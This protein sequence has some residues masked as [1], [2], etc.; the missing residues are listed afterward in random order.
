MPKQPKRK[1]NWRRIVGLF[2]LVTLIFSIGYA[3]VR[4]HFAP[5]GDEAVGN[6]LQRSDYLLM[7]IQCCLGLIVI[8]LPGFLDR[9]FSFDLPNY[10]TIMYFVFFVLRDLSRRSPPVFLSRAPLGHLLARI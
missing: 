10:M 5:S 9:K 3:L 2:V 1:L 6:E 4:F 7:L 8:F